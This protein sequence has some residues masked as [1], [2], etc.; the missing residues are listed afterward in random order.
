MI[1]SPGRGVN[2]LRT[3]LADHADGPLDAMAERMAS[4]AST[5]L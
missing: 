1:A 3:G 5:L 2:R 4:V